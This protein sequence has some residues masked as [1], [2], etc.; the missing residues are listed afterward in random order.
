MDFDFGGVGIRGGI[1]GGFVVGG[2]NY[3]LHKRPWVDYL[4]K[5]QEL[6]TKRL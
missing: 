1:P 6:L 3:I 5:G 2:W 4:R